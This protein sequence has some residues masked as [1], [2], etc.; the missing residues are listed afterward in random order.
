M[1]IIL[2]LNAIVLI[3]FLSL[4]FSILVFI[5]PICEALWNSCF[6]RCYTNKTDCHYDHLANNSSTLN[7]HILVTTFWYN[8]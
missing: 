1:H 5:S 4:M 8:Q 2:I 6:E 3:F 7:N